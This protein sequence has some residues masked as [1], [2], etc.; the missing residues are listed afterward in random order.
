M[1]LL[2]DVDEFVVTGKMVVV[3][4]CV[5]LTIFRLLDTEAKGHYVSSNITL[6]SCDLLVLGN[7]GV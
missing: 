5:V 1:Y 3:V 7:T 2:F 6:Q 4:N